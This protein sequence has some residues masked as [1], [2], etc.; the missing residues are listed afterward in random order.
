MKAWTQNE[1]TKLIS[2]LEDGVMIDTLCEAIPT[3]TEAAIVTRA[4]NKKF[5]LDYRTSG[6]DRKLYKGVS[7]RYQKTDDIELK[8]GIKDKA[9]AVGAAQ[10]PNKSERTNQNLSDAS[11]HYSD[12]IS[13]R[14]VFMSLYDDVSK[15]LNS[16]RY[17]NLKSI[18]VSLE[19]I[20]ITV[21]KGST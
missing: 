21:S 2:L 9:R 16:E 7:R 8:K 15:L 13:N 14:D 17:S 5:G 18:T 4:R 1:H 6:K 20:A 11:I 12:N 3:R 10:M 19:D